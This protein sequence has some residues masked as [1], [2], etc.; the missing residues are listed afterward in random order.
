MAVFGD[1]SLPPKMHLIDVYGSQ[2]QLFTR[3]VDPGPSFLG[4]ARGAKGLDAPEYDVQ[5]DAYPVIDGEFIRHVRA[6]GREIFLPLVFYGDSRRDLILKKRAFLRAINPKVGTVR[7]V[8]AEALLPATSLADPGTYEDTREIELYYSHG[9][10]GDEGDDNGLHWLKVGVVFRATYPF[11]QSSDELRF[12]FLGS[13]TPPVPFFAHPTTPY[14]GTPWVDRVFRLS[15]PAPFTQTIT[16]DNTGDGDDYLTWLFAGPI[17]GPFELT[18]TATALGDQV[19]SLYITEDFVLG[20]GQTAQIVT[21]PG[22]QGVI[23]NLGLNF[24]VFGT[25]PNFWALAP[26]I[27]NIEIKVPAFELDANGNPTAVPRPAIAPA[28]VDVSYHP[29][30]IGW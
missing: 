5:T 18:R 27:N 20:A 8:T 3:Y 2:V 16:I 11:F 26:G 28:Y 15:E 6:Q 7:L 19:D 17:R 10:E 23:S 22:S 24:S 1:A 4:V 9:F 13:V 21:R 12:P 14:P 29:T 25:N 30:F